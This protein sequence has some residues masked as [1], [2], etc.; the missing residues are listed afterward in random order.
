[1]RPFRLIARLNLPADLVKR[2]INAK[3]TLGD[4]PVPPAAI[5]TPTRTRCQAVS[6]KAN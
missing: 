2:L 3:Y 1:M 4:W 6:R 5:E